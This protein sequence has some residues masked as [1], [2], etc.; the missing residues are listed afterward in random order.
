M[1]SHDI[2]NK[3]LQLGYLACGIIPANVFDEYKDYLDRRVKLY[4]ESKELYDPLYNNARQPEN[5]KSIIVCT[6][7]YNIYKVPDYMNRLIGKFYLFDSRVPYSPEYRENAEFETFLQL[8]GFSFFPCNIPDRLA[9]AKAGLGK[10]ARNNF[11][12]DS[13]HGSYLW[14][15]AWVID[16][17]LEYD[18]VEDNIWLPDCNDTC[19]KCIQ[20]CPT[21]A[22]SGSYSMDRGKC[23]THLTCNAKDT[24]NAE[25]RSQM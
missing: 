7:R 5:A 12:Y 24:L 22:L 17:E 10:I 20:S 18:R 21:K 16:K 13:E 4:P 8:L 23:I 19:Q 11:L 6:H 9:A 2:K 1:K 25:L 15:D 3:A 14:I